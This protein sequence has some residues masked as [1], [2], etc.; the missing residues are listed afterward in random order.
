M[1]G[2]DE[3]IIFRFTFIKTINIPV[4]HFSREQIFGIFAI[5][6]K[7]ISCIR[8]TDDTIFYFFFET[9]NVHMYNF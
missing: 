8:L 9:K 5:I 3:R 1:R 6:T 7:I 2:E 4:F